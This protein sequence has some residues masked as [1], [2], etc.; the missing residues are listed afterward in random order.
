MKR[1]LVPLS[2]RESHEAVV[3]L[4]GKLAKQSGATVRLLRVFP[5]PDLIIRSPEFVG[6]PRRVAAYADQQMA[7]LKCKGL[8]Y[9]RTVERTVE[10]QLDGVPVD[11]VV[12]FGDAIQET[13][14]EADVSD[15]DLIAVATT[16]RSWLR[17]T[18]S[19]SVA[20]QIARKASAPVLLLRA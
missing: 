7:V 15:A 11:A 13:L 1:I 6:A 4:V 14:I 5:V 8:D 19:P 2:G 16:R 17:S 18:F 3:P 9:L 10:L 20:E 12:R